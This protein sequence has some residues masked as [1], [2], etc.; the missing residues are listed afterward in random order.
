G[1]CDGSCRARTYALPDRGAYFYLLGQYLVDGYIATARRGVFRL[2]IS[3]SWDYP[4]IL[5]ETADAMSIVSGGNR[6]TIVDRGGCSDTAMSWKHWPCVVPQH[7]PGRRHERSIYLADWQQ[8]ASDNDHI[9]LRG[10]MH[11]DGLRFINPVR[12]RTRTRTL[13][14][15]YVRYVFPNASDDI[16]GILCAS[17][18]ALG[19]EWAMM[20]ARNVS[21]ARRES[22]TLMEALVGPKSRRVN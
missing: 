11:S 3:C 14:Y 2:R 22:V 19:I 10:L 6:V 12:R 1:L 18:D 20:N 17:L 21:I 5:V 15:K 13:Q 7:G 9:D 4:D 8:P 16:R